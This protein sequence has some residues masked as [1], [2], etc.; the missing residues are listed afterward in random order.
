M[1]VVVLFKDNRPV[2]RQLLIVS[3]GMQVENNNAK[4]LQDEPLRNLR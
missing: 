2:N 3:F 4:I 1:Q